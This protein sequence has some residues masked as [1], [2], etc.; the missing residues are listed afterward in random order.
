MQ[1]CERPFWR[2]RYGFVASVFLLVLGASAAKAENLPPFRVDPS[3][4]SGSV[5][6][7]ETMQQHTV[8]AKAAGTPGMRPNAASAVTLGAPVLAAPKQSSHAVQE[9]EVSGG[10]LYFLQFGAFAVRQNA[11]AFRDRL[12]QELKSLRAK[13]IIRPVGELFLVQLGPWPDASAARKIHKQLRKRKGV[14][15]IVAIARPTG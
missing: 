5:L 11:E 3:L 12:A 7:I 4:L 14:T 6:P 9:I 10:G 1:S 13:L 8:V 2:R 15:S